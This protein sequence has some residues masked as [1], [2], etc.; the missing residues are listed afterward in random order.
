MTGRKEEAYFAEAERLYIQEDKTVEQ[1][2]MLLPVCANTLYQW[3]LKGDWGKKRE[4]RLTAPKDMAGRLRR[5]LIRQ[6]ENLEGEGR[7]DPAAYDSIYKT[8]LLLEKLEKT[9]DLRVLGVTVMQAYSDFLKAQEIGP[10]ELQMHGE[11]IRGWFR[12]LE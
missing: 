9:Q 12:S 11:R 2:G 8:F 3:K 10:G 5:D 4:L 6:M 1:I 7:L